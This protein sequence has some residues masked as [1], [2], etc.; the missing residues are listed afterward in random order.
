MEH[1]G[2][3]DDGVIRMLRDDVEL[4]LRIPGINRSFCQSGS[5]LGSLPLQSSCIQVVLLRFSCSTLPCALICSCC[6]AGSRVRSLE[7]LQLTGPINARGLAADR[8]VLAFYA[9]LRDAHHFW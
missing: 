7:G 9:G 1:G 2:T 5:A 4:I 3:E 8:K 6:R